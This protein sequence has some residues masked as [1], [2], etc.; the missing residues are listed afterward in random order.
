MNEKKKPRI[1][2]F[3]FVVYPESAKQDWLTTLADQKVPAFVSPLHDQ[4]CNEDGEVKKPHF[5]VLVMHEG[6]KSLEQI[7][8]FVSLI[9]GVGTEI[10]KSKTGYARYLCHLDSPD[11]ARYDVEDVRS[12]G[13]ADYTETIA[14]SSDK[15][16]CI[17]EMIVYCTQMGIFS[18]AQLFN[19]AMQY[20]R[21]WFR[22]LCDSGTYVVKEYLKSAQWEQDRERM[23]EKN[24]AA[25]KA[26]KLL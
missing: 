25:E 14:T 8:D 15:Y 2:N 16:R 6:C 12:F 18:Y 22:T 21:D 24:A 17:E 26:G 1:R 9:G 13:G 5:H 7:K 23:M 20:R 4:D 10:V 11:K 19:Y 3:A